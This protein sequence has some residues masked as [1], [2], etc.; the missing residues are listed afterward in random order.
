MAQSGETLPV[1]GTAV[2]EMPPG[3][4]WGVADLLC[5]HGVPRKLETLQITEETHRARAGARGT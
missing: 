3:E 1:T 2:T 5:K 4:P